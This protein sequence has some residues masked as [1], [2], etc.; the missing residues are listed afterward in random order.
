M[1]GQDRRSPA[2]GIGAADVQALAEHGPVGVVNPQAATVTAALLAVTA[3]DELLAQHEPGTGREPH[4]DVRRVPGPFGDHH[5]LG[6]VL[7]AAAFLNHRRHGE[8]G[9]C[10]VQ[11]GQ[12]YRCGGGAQAKD[13]PG[14]DRDPK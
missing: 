11:A 14:S 1:A 8:H 5:R 2:R 10:A 9:L 6:Q 12:C 3:E 13:R 7:Q 4:P